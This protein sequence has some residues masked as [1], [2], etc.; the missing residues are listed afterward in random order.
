MAVMD[1][2]GREGREGPDHN[3]CEE[4]RSQLRDLLASVARTSGEFESTEPLQREAD[5]LQT[6]SAGSVDSY[7]REYQ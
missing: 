1:I 2:E 3:S 5:S 6:H 4:L 7:E